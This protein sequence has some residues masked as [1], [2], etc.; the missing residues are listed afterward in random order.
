MDRFGID[1]GG[2]GQASEFGRECHGGG[3]EKWVLGNEKGR[4]L[5]N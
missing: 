3:L 1:I 2:V 5:Q 4:Q